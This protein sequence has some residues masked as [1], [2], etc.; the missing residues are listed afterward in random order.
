MIYIVGD[1]TVSSFSEVYYYPRA[2]WGTEI[3]TYFKNQDV[4]NLALSGRS[5]KSFLSEENYKKFL[6]I[7]SGDFVFIGFGHNDEKHD[8]PNRFTN[9]SLSVEDKDSFKYSLYYNYCKIALDKGA[10]PILVTPICRLDET[11]MYTDAKIHVTKFGDYKKAII[12]LGK[13]KNIDVVDLTSY[14]TNLA[15]EQGYEKS[16]LM[17]AITKAKLVDGKLLPD[18]LTVDPTHINSYGAKVYAYFIA[19]TLDNTNNPIKKYIVKPLISPTENDLVMCKEYKY[20]PYSSPD[21]SKY[22]PKEWF[23][24]KSEIYFGSAFGDTGRQT[25][26][27]SNGFSAVSENE[28]YIVGQLLK[29]ESEYTPLGK[30]SLNSEGIAAVARQVSIN[31]NFTFTAH[32]YVLDY[33]PISLSGFGV[34]LRDDFYINQSIA[35]KTITSNYVACGMVTS[36]VDTTINFSR[37]NMQLK[38]TDN[39]IDGFYNIGDELDFKIVRLGQVVRVYTTYKGKTYETIYTDFDFVRIDKDYFYITL[40][41]TRNTLV[42]FT[43]ITYKY[44]GK[45]IGA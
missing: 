10:T 42:K 2:G 17:H 20:V 24:T 44:D 21:F 28:S 40:F 5:S 3:K 8:D 41:A 43:N 9:A 33:A 7:S 11:N 25:I 39:K 4:L 27:N 16:C 12:E 45:A 22:K 30:I 1:S 36:E 31:D 14:S 26:E 29:N 35:D 37:E 18:I 38:K 15:K 32:A 23:D 34:S 6:N 13:E 19:Q